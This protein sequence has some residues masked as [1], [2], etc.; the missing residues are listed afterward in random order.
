M[1]PKILCFKVPIVFKGKNIHKHILIFNIGFMR[2]LTLI[3]V[4]YVTEQ[5][6]DFENV[7]TV[8]KVFQIK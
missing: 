5:S 8:T 1:W 7:W 3:F 6:P 2:L 4:N